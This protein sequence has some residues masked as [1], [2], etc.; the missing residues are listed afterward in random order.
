MLLK[1][2]DFHGKSSIQQEEGSLRRQIGLK[3]KEGTNKNATFGAQLCMVLKL[4]HFGKQIINI[5][6]GLKCGAGER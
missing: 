6:K 1:I 4:G 5:R 2:Q 3:F